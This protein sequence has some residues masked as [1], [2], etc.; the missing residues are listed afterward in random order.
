MNKTLAFVTLLVLGAVIGFL[1]WSLRPSEDMNYKVWPIT[2]NDLSKTEQLK[3]VSFHK[4]VLVGQHRLRKGVFKDSE[5][6]IYVV[7]PATINVGFDLS[8]CNNQ[9]I[10]RIGEDSVMVTLPP[11]EV[12]NKDGLAV[13]EA[14]KHTAIENGQWGAKDMNMLR[15]RAEA[16]MLRNCEAD[17]CYAMAEQLGAKM[18]MAMVKNLGYEN[19]QVEVLPRQNYGLAL[20]GKGVRGVSSC[21]FYESEGE[22]FLMTNSSSKAKVSKMYYHN[23]ELT[24]PQLLAMGDFFAQYSKS[25]PGDI[26]VKIKSSQLFLIFRHDE[27]VP[28]SKEAVKI[29]KKAV[30]RD[31]EYFRQ[32]VSRRIFGDKY[33]MKVVDTGKGRKVIHS[34]KVIN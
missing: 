16:I 15:K 6:K 19:V 29:A 5:D 21:R 27:V 26:E 24:Y 3:V 34:S 22:R 8:K 32:A 4:E 10:R 25:H 11:V 28:D 2:I 20:P 13:D 17:S 1:I 12:L 30:S 33:K 14:D 23:G 18:V 9:S 7:Y 31:L